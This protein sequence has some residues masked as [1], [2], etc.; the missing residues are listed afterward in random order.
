MAKYVE[1]FKN[2]LGKSNEDEAKDLLSQVDNA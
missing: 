1:E 2:V